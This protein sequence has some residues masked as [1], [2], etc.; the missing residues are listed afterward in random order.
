MRRSTSAAGALRAQQAAVALLLLAAAVSQA[1]AIPLC[2]SDSSP[3]NDLC[4]CN[5]GY[6]ETLNSSNLVETCT[7]C[8][9]NEFSVGGAGAACQVREGDAG[10]QRLQGCRPRLILPAP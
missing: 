9:V 6:F 10:H 2:P 7:A 5:P 8:D 4:R 1:G 3:D